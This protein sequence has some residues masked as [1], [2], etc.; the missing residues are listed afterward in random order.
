MYIYPLGLQLFAFIPGLSLSLSLSLA[1]SSPLP[2]ASPPSSVLD[3]NPLHL[4]L[5]PWRL[6]LY[7]YPLPICL[8]PGPASSHLYPLPLWPLSRA[9]LERQRGK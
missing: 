7:D 9:Y 3:L 6:H 2:P 8:Y 5:Y 1:A 4:C